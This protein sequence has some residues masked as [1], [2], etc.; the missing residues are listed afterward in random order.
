MAERKPPY[1][2]EPYP[3][4]ASIITQNHHQIQP[5]FQRRQIV[6]FRFPGLLELHEPQVKHAG[7]REQRLCTAN[8]K[9]SGFAR[10]QE[11]QSLAILAV[12]SLCI[13]SRLPLRVAATRGCRTSTKQ[14]NRNQSRA[15]VQ[16][17]TLTRDPPETKK[18][19]RVTEMERRRR[20][21]Q[22]ASAFVST[23]L[24]Q[25]SRYVL[26]LFSII[27]SFAME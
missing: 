7:A 21:L 5:P 25:S 15:L 6:Q 13:T 9:V 1:G 10:T 18:L 12:P 2:L 27:D 22:G 24:L 11:R 8:C 23:M 17:L 3:L 19:R 16:H 14:N 26:L 20:P 4:S